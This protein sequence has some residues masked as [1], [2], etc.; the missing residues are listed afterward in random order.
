MLAADSLR[1]LQ[2]ALHR[3]QLHPANNIPQDVQVLLLVE[4]YDYCEQEMVATVRFDVGKRPSDECFN[5]VSSL[6]ADSEDEMQVYLPE[7]FK[8]SRNTYY[9]IGLFV[10]LTC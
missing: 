9:L 10:D 4:G 1:L 3:L 5:G 6:F 2:S 8:N 7:M